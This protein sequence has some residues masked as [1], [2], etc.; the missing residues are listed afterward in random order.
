[1]DADS[2]GGTQG[3]C[4]W[5]G[6]GAEDTG[7]IQ[8]RASGDMARTLF[9]LQWK[10]K[11]GFKHGRDIIWFLFLN[12]SC[13]FRLTRGT[14]QTLH[15]QGPSQTSYIRKDWYLWEPSPCQG[16]RQWAREPRCR[17]RSDSD[18]TRV[19]S[20]KQDG[21]AGVRVAELL[22]IRC[23]CFW[24]WMLHTF[25]SRW[26]PFENPAACWAVAMYVK[27]TGETDVS[28]PAEAYLCFCA[29]IHPVG[30]CPLHHS[31]HPC[32]LRQ[33]PGNRGSKKSLSF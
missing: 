11:A 7:P 31:H 15:H 6:E 29:S 20:C 26:L 2:A 16:E 5:K 19:T 33:H 1:M 9:F 18:R 24:A 30:S 8:G 25:N 23:S 32:G 10:A 14:F 28:P 4:G 27:V 13:T 3:P 21:R 17:V 22:F 12:S